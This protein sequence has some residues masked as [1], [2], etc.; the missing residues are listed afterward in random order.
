M[1]TSRARMVSFTF[2]LRTLRKGRKRLRKMS[3]LLYIDLRDWSVRCKAKKDHSAPRH[4]AP[5][6]SSFCQQRFKFQYV[7]ALDAKKRH[8][9]PR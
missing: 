6:D 2:C 8:F 9:T 7:S 1:R 3:H 5:V 4:V